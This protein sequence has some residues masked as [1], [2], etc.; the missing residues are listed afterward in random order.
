M[1]ESDNC[2]AKYFLKRNLTGISLSSE[3]SSSQ[4]EEVS[5][6][7]DE[8]IARQQQNL[9]T[10]D[11][12]QF[13]ERINSIKRKTVPLYDVII[14]AVSIVFRFAGIVFSLMVAMDYYWKGSVDYMIYTVMCLIIPILMT[15]L[16]SI[17]L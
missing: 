15:S 7:S 14:N 11:N 9:D 8:V 3:K 2:Y 5:E 17:E 16:I 4:D 13:R 1:F 12:H 6:K 10:T